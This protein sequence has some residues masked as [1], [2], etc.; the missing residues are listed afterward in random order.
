M[1]SYTVV[2]FIQIQTTTCTLYLQQIF[3]TSLTSRHSQK[4]ICHDTLLVNKPLT[5]NLDAVITHGD[6]V[7]GSSGEIT[8]WNLFQRL[9]VPCLKAM[10]WRLQ[11]IWRQIF[12]CSEGERGVIRS[13]IT[14]THRA[15]NNMQISSDN[16][17]CAAGFF[18]SRISRQENIM[19]AC[20]MSLW[21][22]GS[23]QP[24]SSLHCV[25]S[26]DTLW[27]QRCV[28]DWLVGLYKWEKNK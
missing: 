16:W 26:T 15:G 13:K 3:P 27:W 23:V 18:W 24:I 2:F 19:S 22:H 17:G 5:L 20:K 12:Q 10:L 6:S 28:R 1:A 4:I 8:I 9:S 25:N 11:L 14:P 7:Y 21:R